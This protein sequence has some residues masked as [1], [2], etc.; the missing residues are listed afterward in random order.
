MKRTTGLQTGVVAWNT[1]QEVL[2]AIRR[3]VF[4]AEQGVPWELELD[5]LDEQAVHF[6][7]TGAAGAIAVARL[8][9][10]GQVGRMAVLAAHRYRGVGTALLRYIQHWARENGRDNL[11]LHA[12]E[13]AI[14]FYRRLGFRE[15]GETFMDAGIPHRE[16]IWEYQ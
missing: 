16:M 6:L 12:Q 2:L 14:D 3:E 10:S 4:V 1:E 7:T 9:S 8:L 15:R 5:G 13:H 11:F